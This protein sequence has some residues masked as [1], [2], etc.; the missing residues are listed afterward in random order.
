MSRD[1]IVVDDVASVREAVSSSHLVAVANS[2]VC[3]ARTDL[4]GQ[5]HLRWKVSCV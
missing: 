1:G 3:I 5:M 4:D 2:T